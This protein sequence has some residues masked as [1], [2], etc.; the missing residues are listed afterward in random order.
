MCMPVH[1]DVAP[2][3]KLNEAETILL[4][5]STILAGGLF[6]LS[7]ARIV[8]ASSTIEVIVA[9][10]VG[11]LLLAMFLIRRR[12]ENKRSV[13]DKGL[14]F[15]KLSSK[16]SSDS[17]STSTTGTEESAEAV[18]PLT[19]SPPFIG[20]FCETSLLDSLPPLIPEKA[21]RP[22]SP[23]A[24]SAPIHLRVE[25]EQL[26][27]N[28]TKKVRRES[29]P[30]ARNVPLHIRVE[31]ERLRL[32]LTKKN[33]PE[34]VKTTATSLRFRDTDGRTIRYTLRP[35]MKASRATFLE[36]NVEG[37]PRP[38]KVNKMT[39]DGATN[40][41]SVKTDRFL[42]P[43]GDIDTVMKSLRLLCKVGGVRL[44]AIN[45]PPSLRAVLSN[46]DIY[47]TTMRRTMSSSALSQASTLDL[48][49]ASR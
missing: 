27:L 15:A 5:I 26:Q 13:P 12:R 42:V 30:P 49:I 47:G 14:T 46:L 19:P 36:L 21:S 44:D 22:R 10:G 3:N 40:A 20:T 7:C 6:G 45:S 48:S 4:S 32:S 11:L 31:Q 25:Q 35:S 18:E 43:S 8:P 37:A 41:I 29:P 23:K 1:V 16:V 33:D 2:L 38:R 9:L 17:D 34:L 28:S 24:N 39:Y